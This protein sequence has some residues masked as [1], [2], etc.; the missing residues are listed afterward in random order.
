MAPLGLAGALALVAGMLC[1]VAQVDAGVRETTIGELLFFLGW[2]L[3]TVSM[4]REVGASR[5]GLI[6]LA[7]GGSAL[8]AHQFVATDVTSLGMFVYVLAFHLVCSNAEA[9]P[10]EEFDRRYDSPPGLLSISEPETYL[11][12]ADPGVRPPPESD[13]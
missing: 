8:V 2:V 4:A 10:K 3:L 11:R 5:P 9:L 7:I 6:V 12:R 13:V 1:G